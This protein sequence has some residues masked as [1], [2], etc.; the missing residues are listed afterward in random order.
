MSKIKTV[1]LD[2]WENYFSSHIDCSAFRDKIELTIYQQTLLGEELYRAIAEAEV[3]ILLRERTAVDAAFI[4]NAPCL[5]HIICTGNQVRNLDAEAVEKAGISLSFAKGGDSKSS[6][7]EL[8]WALILAAYKQLDKLRIG[9][10]Q[11]QWR[12]HAENQTAFIPPTLKDKQLGLIGLGS[13]GQKMAGV[14]KAFG[15]NVVCWS[16]NMTPERA[17][18]HGVDAVSLAHLLAESDIISIHMV[19]GE[20]TRHLLHADN[21][22][23]FKPGAVLVNTSRAEIIDP[24][25]LL[26]ALKDGTPAFYATDV[27]ETEPLPSDH[28]YYSLDNVLM[29][30][31]F[32]FVAAEVYQL[33][34]EN[35]S[36]ELRA[37]LS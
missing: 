33:F 5:K 25:A 31:H 17:A 15:M 35:I 36:N 20:S 19:L 23:L 27:F 21:L 8:T 34:A 28:P 30:A 3:I 16:P 9:Q 1:M 11:K 29:S 26:S 32:G 18:E 10:H 12:Q 24:E 14:A 2:D 4:A 37:Y 22:S 7:C 13:I 6:T